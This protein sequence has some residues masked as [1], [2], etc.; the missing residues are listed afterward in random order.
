MNTGRLITHSIRALTRYR[1]R[2]FFIMMASLVGVAALTLVLSIGKGAQ[3]KMLATVRQI[4]GDSAI[5]IG[6][7]PHQIMGGPRADSARL[8]IDDIDAIARALPEIDV[9]DPQQ[10]LSA[11]VRRGD[12]TATV[13]VLGQSERSSRVWGRGVSRGIYFDAAAVQRTERVALI[14]RTAARNLFGEGDPLRGEIFIEAVPFTVIGILEVFGTDLHGMDR[15]NEIVV[16][17]STLMRRLAN[18]DTISA[19]KLLVK[20]SDRIDET[21]RTVRQLLRSRH[22]LAAGQPDDFNLLTPVEVKQMMGKIRRVLSLY[23]PLASI[24][25]LLVGGIVA[26]TLMLGSVNAR[27]AEI[28]LRRAVGARPGDIGMQFL[29]ETTV[30]MVGGGLGGIVLGLAAAQIVAAH[31]HLVGV[32]SW[33]T[34]VLGLLESAATGLLAGVIPARRAAG[35]LPADALR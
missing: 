8:T 28:G 9:W 24:V 2:S 13:R 3:H 15:D 14:G 10:A 29:I 25:V 32:F 35:L 20:D 33:S 21:A 18:V 22:A 23:L 1:L 17:V 12:A 16:P 27:V 7:G 4:F 6:A 19:A 31:L 11:S 26:A 30:T 34:I 5:L